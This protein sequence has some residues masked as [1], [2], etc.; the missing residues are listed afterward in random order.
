MPIQLLVIA[1][2]ANILARVTYACA[3]KHINYCTYAD[4]ALFLEV[5]PRHTSPFA[6]DTYIPLARRHRPNRI[7][8]SRDFDQN[9]DD[10]FQPS[11]N[12]LDI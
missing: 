2:L 5:I 7:L 10:T 9:F 3:G 11:L 1:Y 12:Q 4:I 8:C 6:Q